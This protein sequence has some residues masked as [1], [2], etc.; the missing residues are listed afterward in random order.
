MFAGKVFFPFIFICFFSKSFFFFFFRLE[1][2]LLSMNS[3]Y[4]RLK[5]SDLLSKFD[6]KKEPNPF[7]STT[8]EKSSQDNVEE[9]SN[10][11]ILDLSLS[12]QSDILA[13]E[14]LIRYS[15]QL[16]KNQNS[17]II[18]CAL[19]E[20]LKQDFRSVNFLLNHEETKEFSDVKSTLEWIRMIELKN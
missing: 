6:K 4:V 12:N 13:V 1:E 20:K 14:S 3:E 17:K 10:Y 11:L 5:L 8:S 19:N 15:K 18:V 2:S 16:E 9:L 7:Q